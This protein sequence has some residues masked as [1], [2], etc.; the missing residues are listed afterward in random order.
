MF[1]A[2]KEADYDRFITSRVIANGQEARF[3]ASRDLFPHGTMYAEKV[4][5]KDEVMEGSTL[6]IKDYYHECGVS[7][8][9]ALRTQ[10]GKPRHLSFFRGLG[11]ADRFRQREGELPDN[12]VV[13]AVQKTLPMGDGNATDLAEVGRV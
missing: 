1:G 5:Q 9:R 4:L 3:R 2:F 10:L 8:A 12:T 13:I 11:A 6:D 7:R